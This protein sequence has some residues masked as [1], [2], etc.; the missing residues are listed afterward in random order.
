MDS[1]NRYRQLVDRLQVVRRNN[2][3]EETPSELALLEEMRLLWPM[4]SE[5]QAVKASADW[6][7]RVDRRMVA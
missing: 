5:S 3:E 4:L 7:N 6:T 2:P 1:L